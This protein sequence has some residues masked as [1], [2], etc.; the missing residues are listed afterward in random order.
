MLKPKAIPRDWSR[1]FEAN[2]RKYPAAS[3]DAG[4]GADLVETS[5]GPFAADCLRE[6]LGFRSVGRHDARRWSQA[7]MDGD[8]PVQEDLGLTRALVGGG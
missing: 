2:T 8:S 3:R 5:S 1:V 4:P 7:I 6:M